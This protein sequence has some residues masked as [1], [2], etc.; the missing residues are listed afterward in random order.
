MPFF[1][2]NIPNKVTDDASVYGTII[3]QF[4]LGSTG[5]FAASRL[6]DTQLGRKWTV[7][8]SYICCGV[9]SFLFLIASNY[10]MILGSTVLIFFFSNVGFASFFLLVPENYPTNIRAIGQSWVNAA[11]K[12]GGA[13]SPFTL[14]FMVELNNGVT[15][16]VV[17]IALAYGIIGPIGLM[18]KETRGRGMD[19]VSLSDTIKD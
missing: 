4:T 14:G 7:I 8:I 12:L 6:V 19:A 2:N 9:F 13:L 16:G 15:I 3:I 18:V 10:F 5:I 1:L 11:G 17:V